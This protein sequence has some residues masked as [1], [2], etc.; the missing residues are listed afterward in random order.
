MTV[1]LDSTALIDALRKKPA[2]VRAMQNVLATGDILA[3][4]A[5]NVAE[6]YA[7]SRQDEGKQTERL[8]AAIEVYPVTY[9]IAKRAGELKNAAARR[10]ITLQLDDMIVAATALERGSPVWTD[11]K[12]DFAVPGLKFYNPS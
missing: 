9:S 5:V 7:G 8:L 6:I 4:S 1:I 3:T 11:N 12:K 10:G 2:C